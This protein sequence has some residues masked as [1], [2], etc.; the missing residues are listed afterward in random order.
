VSQASSRER[1]EELDRE[2]PLGHVR[3][4]FFLPDGVVYLDGNSLGPLPKAVA[5]TVAGVVS[6]EWGAG[7][8]ASWDG[9]FHLPE[10][11]GDRIAPLIGAGA[12]EVV[13]TDTTTIAL[14]KV[15]GAALAARPG[16]RV[17]VTTETNFPTD[18]YAIAGI[19]RLVGDVEVRVVDASAVADSLDDTV[20][21]TCLTHVNFR[22]GEMFDLSAV[23]SAA[24]RAGA[25]AIWD[26]C[27]SV[28]AVV[29]D[30]ET[31]GVDL[32]V[33]CCYK[34]LNGGPG[35]PAFIYVRRQLQA[36]LENP[37]PGWLGHEAPFDFTTGYRPAVGI[38]RFVT[39]TPPILAMSAL[40]AA[41]DA[42]DGVTIDLVRAKSVA[43]CELFI[44]AVTER[45]GSQLEVA[46]PRDPARRGSQ[47]SLRHEHGY[48]IVQAL[49]ARGVIGD[50]RAPDLCRFGFTPL[51]LRYVDVFDAVE[52]LVAVMESEEYA[53]ERYSA[54]RSVT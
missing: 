35:A 42:W 40:D 4:R 23:T 14:I 16:R 28:G 22:T 17:I 54:R 50:F 49:I 36:V 9:W 29:V 7:L 19:A 1:C 31:D 46:S 10:R 2:D 8:S 27:H 3:N 12:G 48:A 45:L 47:V 39:S 37:L 30:C 51:Y 44:S 32:A 11:I 6:D 41:L 15:L 13:V 26:L 53:D 21:A 5:P 25:L 18:L 43:M 33:G 52:Q 24:H 34:Y 20:A 38:Q